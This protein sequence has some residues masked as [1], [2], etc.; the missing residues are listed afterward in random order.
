MNKAVITALAVVMVCMFQIMI[1]PAMAQYACGLQSGK[2]ATYNWSITYSGMGQSYSISGT[3]DIN[4]QSVSGSGYTGTSKETVTGGSL[5]TGILNIPETN[6]TF[7][8][9]VG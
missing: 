4:I 7:S 1:L 8:G 2:N 5:P 6:Q 9:D 3:L